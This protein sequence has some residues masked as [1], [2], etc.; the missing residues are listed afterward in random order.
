MDLSITEQ[1]T[2]LALNPEK[3]RVTINDLH[4]RY[5]LTGAL[6]MDF[7]EHDEITTVN[8]RI[9]PSFRKNGDPVHDMIADKMMQSAKN[10]KIST[11]ISR[12]TNKSRMIFS[13]IISSL[14]KKKILRK[15]KRKFLNIIP[16]YRYWFIDKSIRSKLI[17]TLRGILL[18]GKH[19]SK[20]EIILLSLVEA[21]R[22]YQVL[23]SERGESK[24]LRKK[25]SDLLKGDEISAEISQAIR[26]VK[27][28]IIAS[29]TAATVAAHSGH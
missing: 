2:I 6:I 27:A 4:F 20:R 14:E 25:N 9:V 11:W 29:T 21:S 24:Q 22:A 17:E 5:T 1:F 10:R 18:Y 26:E 13:D 19:P 8:K 12:L 15:E 28:S 16:Y 7:L 23:S 3:G